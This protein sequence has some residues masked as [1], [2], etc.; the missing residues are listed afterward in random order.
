[1]ENYVEIRF[2][3]EKLENKYRKRRFIPKLFHIINILIVENFNEIKIKPI[4]KNRKLRRKREDLGQI[5]IISSL[6][7]A[8]Y[9]KDPLPYGS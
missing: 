5:R 9:S 4:G 8:A 1:M 7:T 3:R 6:E 2:Q